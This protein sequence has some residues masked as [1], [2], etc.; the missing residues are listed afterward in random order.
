MPVVS[1]KAIT[2]LTVASVVCTCPP[3]PPPRPRPLYRIMDDTYLIYLREQLLKEYKILYNRPEN[4][5]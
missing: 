1:R 3:P 2:L 4:D 5:K